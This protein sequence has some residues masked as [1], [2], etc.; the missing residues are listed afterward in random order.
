M[1]RLRRAVGE[2]RAEAIL[3]HRRDPTG[4]RTAALRPGARALDIDALVR[5]I[6]RS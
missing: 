6:G 4:V 3:V 1:L 2:D 5:A